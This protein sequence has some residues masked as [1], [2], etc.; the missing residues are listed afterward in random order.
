MREIKYQ[1]WH[2]TL[3]KMY[4]V[5]ELDLVNKWVV[6]T[7][8]INAYIEQGKLREYTGLKDRHGVEIY[9]GDIVAYYEHYTGDYKHKANHLPV[10]FVEGRFDLDSTKKVSAEDLAYLALNNL[11]EVIGTICENPELLK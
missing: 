8:G 1:F 11:C 7:T 2:D 10:V 9:E 3:K 4:D 5:A 6:S